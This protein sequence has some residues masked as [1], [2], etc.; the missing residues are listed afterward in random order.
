MR[1]SFWP[2]REDQNSTPRLKG[3]VSQ[4]EAHPEDAAHSLIAS[5]QPSLAAAQGQKSCPTI[6]IPRRDVLQPCPPA[7]RPSE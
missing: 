1:L 7:V 6:V 3:R 2:N 5:R 4:L